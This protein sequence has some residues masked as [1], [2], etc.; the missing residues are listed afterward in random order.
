MIKRFFLFCVL[1]RIICI[2]QAADLPTQ[3]LE[4][5]RINLSN[6]VKLGTK[7]NQANLPFPYDYLL[8]QPL[9][10]KGIEKY[11]QCTAIIQT[12]Y[13]KK[14][15]TNNTFFRIILMLLKPNSKLKEKEAPV[16]ELAFI[17][18]NFKELPQTIINDVLDTNIPFGKSLLKNHFKTRSR[19]RQYFSVSCDNV[20]SSLTHCTLNRKL[21]GRSNTLLRK[22]NNRW[23]ARVVEILM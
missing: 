5:K 8:T 19:D 18:M 17:T 9:M 7:V 4:Q 2:S 1:I 20:L 14:N 12:V 16:V 13:A 3:S 10:T 23:I 22:D 6:I 11:Y 21:Y 15:S